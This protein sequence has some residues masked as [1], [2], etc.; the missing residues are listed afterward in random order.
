VRVIDFT[1]E[2]GPGASGAARR[3]L[4]VDDHADAAEALALLLQRDGWK[5]HV[6][7]DGPAALEAVGPF[8][9]DIVLL[10]VFLPGID[11]IEVCRRL[12][13]SVPDLPVVA[14]TGWTRSVDHGAA[15]AH[16]FDALVAKPVEP[17]RLQALLRTLLPTGP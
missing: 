4:V 11:G 12:K 14:I 13:A 3:V 8:A 5:T 10:D 7:L 2:P 17:A 6:C 9:P 15:A 1:A 16:G